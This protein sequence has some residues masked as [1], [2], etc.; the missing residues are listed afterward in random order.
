VRRLVEGLAL[1][2]D[3]SACRGDML[4]SADLLSQGIFL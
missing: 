1:D 4:V 2:D 3:P